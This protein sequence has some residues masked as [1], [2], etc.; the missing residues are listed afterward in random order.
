MA[1]YKKID[2]VD[3]SLISKAERLEKDFERSVAAF[4]KDAENKKSLGKDGLQ[5]MRDAR[6]GRVDQ[7]LGQ[8]GYKQREGDEATGWE[9]KLWDRD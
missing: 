6:E 8:E 4:L 5:K 7:A 9:E 1:E 3:Q 2:E